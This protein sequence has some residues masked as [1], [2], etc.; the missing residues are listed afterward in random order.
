MHHEG[1][2]GRHRDLA[3]NRVRV[4]GNWLTVIDYPAVLFAEL[5]AEMHV[6]SRPQEATINRNKEE[7]R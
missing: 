4:D 3:R 7:K 1:R 5:H 2:P 6:A